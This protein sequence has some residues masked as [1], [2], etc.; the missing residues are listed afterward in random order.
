M[1]VPTDAAGMEILQKS[2]A[3]ISA[4]EELGE[5]T[6]QALAA[7][8]GEP[9][10]STYRL[11]ASL[12]SIGWVDATTRRGYFRLG[13]RFVRVGS[14]LEDQ[15][16][17]RD[18]C[19]PALEALR[20]HTNATT[21]LCFLRNDAAVCVERLA[22]RDVQSLAMRLGDSLPLFRGAAPLALFAFLPDG[23][24][25]ATLK[26]FAERRRQGEAIPSDKSLRSTLQ[27]VRDRGYSLSDQDVTPGI[28]GIGAPVFNH[29][30]ELEGAI[31][32]SGLR[33]QILSGENDVAEATVHAAA[34]ASRAL[35]AQIQG[36]RA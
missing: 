4:L 29:R 18:A 35:G 6:A 7:H 22:G 23:E 10:S 12:T 21:F 33:N 14:L 26:R 24:R 36:V 13:V 34:E 3:V 16:S 25:D 11:L 20:S 27:L 2:G 5:E 15:L 30:G 31:S 19:R 28:A 9:V 8:V 1:T 17:V 32:V